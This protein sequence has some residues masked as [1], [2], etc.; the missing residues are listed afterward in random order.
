[1]RIAIAAIVLTTAFA[2][3]AQAR[4]SLTDVEYLQAARCSGLAAA[5]GD[6]DAAAIDAMLKTEA[7]GRNA[8]IVDKG[9]STKA[10]AKRT[11]TRAK[12]E[13]K[14]SLQAELSSACA[15]YAG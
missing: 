8:Y 1:M 6:T 14:A 12:D 15:R 11:A 10:D 13:R 3:A 7:R 2:G 4:A 9:A 5:L